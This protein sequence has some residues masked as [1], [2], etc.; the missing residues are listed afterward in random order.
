[1]VPNLLPG[2]AY[3]KQDGT[4]VVPGYATDS[5]A[6]AGGPRDALWS[7]FE[8]LTR[9]QVLQRSEISLTQTSEFFAAGHNRPQDAGLLSLDTTGG[10][11]LDAVFKLAAAGGRGAAVDISAPKIAIINGV[12]SG[13]AG[14]DPLAT[15]IAATTLNAMGA[16]SLFLGG[17]RSLTTGSDSTTLTVNAGEVTLANDVNHA[18]KGDEIILAA[19]DTLTLKSGSAI[20]TQDD[21]ESGGASYSTA[22][23]GALVRAGS[24]PTA[25]SRTG[26]PDRSQGTLIGEAGSAIRSGN[27]ITLDAT[28]QNTFAGATIFVDDKDNPVAGNLTIGATRIN[29]GNAPA[30]AEGLVFSQSELDGLNSLNSLTLTSYSTFDLYGDVSVGSVSAEGKPTLQALNLLGAGL[31]G[32]NNDGKTANLRATNVLIANPA[33]AVFAAGGTPGNGV[34]AIQA[35]KLVFG[36]GTKA[37]Q[38]FSRVDA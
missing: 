12:P 13:T 37:I 19:K 2:Q 23:N 8:V 10:L 27:S 18:L 30:G 6:L 16:A 3:N 21:A 24:T 29:F 7:G 32:L 5:R 17:T 11:K 25:F 36:E 34:L 20:E 4:Q 35:D 15:R 22:G 31:A 1:D 38:G 33:A 26:S 9:E 14:I 28:K